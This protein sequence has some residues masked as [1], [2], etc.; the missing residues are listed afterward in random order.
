MFKH[1][2]D[3]TRFFYL[4]PL[5]AM[6][7]FEMK[8]YC[9]SHGL[10]YLITSTV[11]THKEDEELGRVSS[12]HR[13]GRAFDLRCKSWPQ[14]SIKKFVDFFEGKYGHIAAISGSSFKRNLIVVH[15][16]GNGIHMHVQIHAR[17]SREIT[18]PR[19]RKPKKSQ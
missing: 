1:K 14:G 3:Q 2:K 19:Q 9:E 10:E 12:S 13:T 11:S 16:S 7:A 15:D 18:L 4:H 5:A 17:F 6:L 8:Y